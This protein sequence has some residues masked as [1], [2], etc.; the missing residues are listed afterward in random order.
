MFLVLSASY[1]SAFANVGL[2]GEGEGLGGGELQSLWVSPSDSCKILLMENFRCGCWAIIGIPLAFIPCE[3][4][5]SIAG[6]FSAFDYDFHA[7]E[8]TVLGKGAWN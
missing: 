7:F 3:V 4:A 1:C 5:V 8:M 6:S 2:D